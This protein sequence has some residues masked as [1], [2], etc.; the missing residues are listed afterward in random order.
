M[1]INFYLTV[2]SRGG[3]KTTKAKPDLIFDEVTIKMNLEIPDML[4]QKPQLT[5]SISIP[6]SAAVPKE[7]DV[8]MQDNIQDAIEAATGLNVRLSIQSEEEK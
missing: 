7:I 5:A 3:V 8:E 6:D 4:F 2:N 1:K